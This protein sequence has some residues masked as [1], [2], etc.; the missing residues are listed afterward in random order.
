MKSAWEMH[1]LGAVVAYLLRMMTTSTPASE[2][3]YF[4]LCSVLLWLR[5]F[6]FLRSLTPKLRVFRA[7]SS[8]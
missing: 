7:N 2:K 8:A 4:R 3:Q 5:R 1:G 6:A